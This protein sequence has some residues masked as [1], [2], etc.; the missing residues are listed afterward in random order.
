MNAERL[1]DRAHAL[2][3]K[4]EPPY[5]GADLT[6]ARRMFSLLWSF[7]LVLAV[8]F[9]AFTPPTEAGDAGWPIIA[10]LLGVNVAI[11]RV[12][13]RR[14]VGFA[15]LLALSYYSI[16]QLAFVQWLTG[17]PESAFRE[18]FVIA[19]VLG[20]GVHPP[21]R[22]AP[23]LLATA[24]VV[25]APLIYSPAGGTAEEVAAHLLLWLSIG[26][27]VMVL[28]DFIRQQRIALQRDQEAAEERARIDALTGLFNRRSFE[29]LVVGEITDSR[30]RGSP[31][32]L[33]II[34]IDEFKEV[35]D[36]YGHLA[37][38][39]CLKDLAEAIRQAVRGRDKW[40]RWG[41]DEFAVLLPETELLAAK[42]LS[43]RLA[44]EVSA[45][46][47]RPDGAPLHLTYGAASL[48]PDDDMASLVERAD[49]ELLAEKRTASRGRDHAGQG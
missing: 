25:A 24:A 44:A 32:S 35:N 8:I 16:L 43:D 36:V 28:M 19:I 27:A 15:T 49:R 21:R 20:A 5:A 47:Q 41:G 33:V 38:D 29:D 12:L 23:F 34:D 18:L 14:G 30:R 42:M 31:L 13:G 10:T 22:A 26:V 17:G 37:G 1:R 4:R 45:R 39:T 48:L 46:C 2:F 11:A 3:A 7:G 6:N 40:F 9:L